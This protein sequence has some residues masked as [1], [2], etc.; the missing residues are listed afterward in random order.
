MTKALPVKCLGPRIL[1]MAIMVTSFL[2]GCSREEPSPVKQTQ[3]PSPQ[4]I[5]ESIPTPTPVDTTDQ[6][7]PIPDQPKLDLSIPD[8]FFAEESEDT[9]QPSAP[10]QNIF[11][12]G[13][14]PATKE[15]SISGQPIIDVNKQDIR[16]S[17]LEGGQINIEIK[18]K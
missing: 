8:S 9:S 4:T 10:A 11:D 6:P 1:L 15:F 17:E 12:L 14:K 5:P 3:Q 18:T 13:N 2:P 7:S 16:D